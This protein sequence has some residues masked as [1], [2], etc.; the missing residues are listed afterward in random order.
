MARTSWSAPP[1]NPTYY[2]GN[3]ILLAQPPVPGGE[4]EVVGAFHTEFPQAEHVSVGID[5]ADLSDD[6]RAA[7]E[8]AGLE[9]DV[10]SVLTADRPPRRRVRRRWSCGPWSPTTTGRAAPG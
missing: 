6:A 8:A 9:V 7:F 2:W 5:R 1:A 3:F 4:R 10:A